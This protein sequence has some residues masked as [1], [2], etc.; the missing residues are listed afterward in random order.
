M[1]YSS[2]IELFEK[3][4]WE[5]AEREKLF[6]ESLIEYSNEIIN[7]DIYS[8]MEEGYKEMANLNLEY[9]EMGED[10]LVF[11]EYVNWLSGEW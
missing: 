9:A 11:N 7:D 5:N 3:I 8:E 6:D 1:A 4:Y 10:S 2:D